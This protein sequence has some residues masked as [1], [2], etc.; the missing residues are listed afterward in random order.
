MTASDGCGA[1]RSRCPVG[2]GAR[3][4]WRKVNPKMW[5]GF[6]LQPLSTTA[7]FNPPAP[8]GVRYVY[9]YAVCVYKECTLTA[10]I[11]LLCTDESGCSTSQGEPKIS[12][13]P[14]N[15]PNSLPCSLE[16]PSLSLY[17]INHNTLVMYNWSWNHDFSFR[18]DYL[19]I[20]IMA[21]K[22]PT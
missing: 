10:D 21:I 3:R 4:W 9:L 5:R 16:T 12:E 6:D 2:L 17:L 13:I 1:R 22:S 18:K 15:S 11:C 20:E 14:W 8:K 19:A 7:L